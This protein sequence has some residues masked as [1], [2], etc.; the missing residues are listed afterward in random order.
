MRS[1]KENGYNRRKSTAACRKWIS[2]RY[3]KLNGVDHDCDEYPFAST[4]NGSWMANPDPQAGSHFSVRAIPSKDN[5]RGGIELNGFYAAQRVIDMDDFYVKVIKEDG[6][7][8]IVPAPPMPPK[9]PQGFVTGDMDDDG[10]PDL[11][12][13]HKNGTGKLRF[14]PGKGDGS[15][16]TG[17]EI[18]P[19][20][21]ANAVFTHGQDFNN[22]EEE[23]VVARVGSELLLYPGKGDGTIGSPIA[24]KG[25]GTGWDTAVRGIVTVGDASNDGYPD[26]IALS[27]DELWLYPGDSSDKPSLLAPMKIGSRGWNNC[28]IIAAGDRTGDGQDDLVARDRKSG[29]M[30][31]YKG[32]L[33][34][35]LKAPPALA[36]QTVI[37]MVN[38]NS[39]KCL[40]IDGSSTRNGAL[41]Q[42]WDC[43]GQAGAQWQIRPDDGSS[44]NSV[45]VI[46][47]NSGKCLEV[48]D[49]RKDNGAP[50]QQWDCVNSETQKWEVI[51]SNNLADPFILRNRNSGKVIE[52]DNS[53]KSNGARVQQWD[54]AGQRGAK[55]WFKPEDPDSGR[56]VLTP[57]QSNATRVFNAENSPLISAGHD[58]DHDGRLDIWATRYDGSLA[59]L[60]DD[61]Q[62]HDTD[63]PQ[64]QINTIKDV[65]KTGWRDIV[66]IG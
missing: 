59:L 4:Y 25:Y 39:E 50:I 53:S 41:A 51:W 43:K 30:F 29:M 55:W 19:D 7:D 36:E 57:N 10:K 18:G 3:S 48:A 37:R 49:S 60:R 2:K 40:E 8:L 9:T 5:E 21:W 42:Q 32:P 22:D 23:D 61:P 47:A 34:R 16:G 20:G 33:N 27:K 6:S 14:Y 44:F 35:E 56:L 13:V 45:S 62:R 26:I 15:L 64:I 1:G 17:K 12:A 66:S 11:L 58:S 24:F 52:V 63:S 31:L 46:N 54:N 28:D 65:E 38:G